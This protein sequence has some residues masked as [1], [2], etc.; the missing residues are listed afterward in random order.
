MSFDALGLRA[1]LLKAIKS[2]GYEAPSAIQSKAIPI[3]LSGRDV[4]AKAQTGTGKT[5]AFALPIVQ[6]LSQTQGNGHHPRALVLAPTRE[7]ALQVG[8]V[9][10]AYARK[11]G[12]RCTVVFG[13]VRIEAQIARLERGIDILVAT[14]GRLLDLA[15]Q[16]CVNLSLVEFLVFD[17]A[18]R[19]LDLGFSREINA[20]L[21]LLPLERR[22]M[23]FSATYTPPIRTLAARMLENPE[24]IEVTPDIT[25]AEAVDQKVLLVNKDNKLAL[26]VHMITTGRWTRLLVFARTRHWANRLTEK[27]SAH[28][29]NAAALHSNKSQSIRKRTLEEFKANQIQVLVATDVAARGLDISDLPFVVNYDMPSQ[30]EDYVHRIGRTGRAGVRGVA[31]SLVCQEEIRFLEA[32]EAFLKQKIPV[33]VIKG[34]TDESDVPDGVLYRPGNPRS[35][36]NAPRVI[37]EMVAPKKPSK[38]RNPEREDKKRDG[39]PAPK[40]D[41]SGRNRNAENPPARS[42]RKSERTAGPAK[43]G[44]SR[45]S[46]NR[47]RR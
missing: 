12:L 3:I 5:D 7:L 21:D 1:E 44:T 41:R 35:E 4:L 45:P 40:P 25:V 43:S 22:T 17:E 13:G 10:K 8:E 37:K 36:R 9:I 29:I 34:F 11:V 19:M 28:H 38:P 31:V 27:L 18:D 39:R 15:E 46:N 26:L 16:N 20:V 24:Y 14:P 42:P 2:R 6:I 33:D 30:P 23:L 32:I 47:G